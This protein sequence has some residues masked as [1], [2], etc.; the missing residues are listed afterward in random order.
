MGDFLVCAS[1]TE[2]GWC[3]CINNGQSTQYCSIVARAQYTILFY[4]CTGTVQLIAPPKSTIYRAVFIGWGK[5]V[6]PTPPKPVRANAP[7]RPLTDLEKKVKKGNREKM[8]FFYILKKNLKFPYHSGHLVYLIIF[9]SLNWFCFMKSKPG[10]WNLS[11]L[12]SPD[13]IQD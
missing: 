13:R 10:T 7:L 2:S 8:F 1:S 4:C 11:F 3:A 6:S 9:T 12:E 5:G